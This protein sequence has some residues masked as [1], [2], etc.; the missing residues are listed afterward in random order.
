MTLSVVVRSPIICH[1]VKHFVRAAVPVT[2]DQDTS[3][4]DT[5]L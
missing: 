3:A 5:T 4:F 1:A 2:D